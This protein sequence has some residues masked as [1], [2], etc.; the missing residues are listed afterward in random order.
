MAASPLHEALRELFAKSPELTSPVVRTH[1]RLPQN[2]LV[3]RRGHSMVPAV[4]GPS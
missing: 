3:E 2:T 1:L 4:H